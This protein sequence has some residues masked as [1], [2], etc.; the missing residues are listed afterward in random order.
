MY[1]AVHLLECRGSDVWGGRA[2]FVGGLVRENRY[3]GML[4]LPGTFFFF[5]LA[6]CLPTFLEKISNVFSGCI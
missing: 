5:F 1:W 3:L 4:E 6:L 2:G